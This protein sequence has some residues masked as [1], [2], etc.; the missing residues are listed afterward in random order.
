[1]DKKFSDATIIR[2]AIRT[3]MAIK[4]LHEHCYLHRDLEPPNLALS[5]D[6]NSRNVYLVDF[7]AARQYARFDNGKWML[8]APRDKVPFRGSVQYCSPKM[9]DMEEVGRVDDLWSWLYIVAEMRVFLPWTDSTH[10]CK[11]APRK[12]TLLD[13]VLESDP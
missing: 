4:S 2:L 10:K 12:R 13:E 6:P 8:R 1:M 9:H 11:F 7:G 5:L 3:L